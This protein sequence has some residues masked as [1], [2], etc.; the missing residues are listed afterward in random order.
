MIKFQLLNI[1]TKSI[2][3]FAIKHFALERKIFILFK[4]S[5]GFK[6]NIM[7]Y[8]YFILQIIF[9]VKNRQYIIYLSQFSCCLKLINQ[10]EYLNIKHQLSYIYFGISL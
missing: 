10:F 5:S 1:L 8:G 9:V 7:I 4:T 6:V 3:F 2:I